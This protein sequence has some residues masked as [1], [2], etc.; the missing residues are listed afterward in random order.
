MGIFPNFWDEN[1]QKIFETTTQYISVYHWNCNSTQ[2]LVKLVKLPMVSNGLKPPG[3]VVPKSDWKEIYQKTRKRGNET[4]DFPSLDSS[5]IRIIH[6]SLG[7]PCCF[8]K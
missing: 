4:C 2:R 7:R 1:F 3:V 8:K 5:D 6:V